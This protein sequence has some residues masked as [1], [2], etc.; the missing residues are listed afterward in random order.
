MSFRKTK[1]QKKVEKL[2]KLAC[3]AIKAMQEPNI[4][5]PKE[6]FAVLKQISKL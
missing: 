5:M 3:Q 6:F 4:N 1:E 2:K